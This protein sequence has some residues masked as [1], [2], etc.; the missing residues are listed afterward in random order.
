MRHNGHSSNIRLAGK[1]TDDLKRFRPKV[2]V[3]AGRGNC[4]GQVSSEV[5]AKRA[6][7]LG[8]SGKSLVLTFHLV[9]YA[10]VHTQGVRDF[11]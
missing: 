4:R 5:F 2:R 9:A 10:S 6:C 1:S 3:K 11:G 8:E 7:S